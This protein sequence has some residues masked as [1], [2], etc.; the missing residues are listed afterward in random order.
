VTTRASMVLHGEQ[1]GGRAIGSPTVLA[2]PSRDDLYRSEPSVAEAKLAR[3]ALLSG[4][5]RTVPKTG[6][7]DAKGDYLLSRKLPMA[8]LF[9]PAAR[10]ALVRQPPKHG[11]H[12]CVARM[13]AALDLDAAAEL[14][15]TDPLLAFLGR[16]CVGCLVRLREQTLQPVLAAARPRLV[17]SADAR[18]PRGMNSQDPQ[19]DRAAW[20][21]RR[22]T[23][24][25]IPAPAYYRG[26]G[27]PTTPGRPAP[28]SAWNGPTLRREVVPRGW[29]R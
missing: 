29:L 9:P 17:A 16:P 10:H 5:W 13:L 23:S 19:L 3:L 21:H 20:R 8:M 18:R 2:L 12:W 25:K 27:W 28:L 14:V 22:R 1:A 24:P 11:C 7:P 4:A 26:R 15:P 6:G